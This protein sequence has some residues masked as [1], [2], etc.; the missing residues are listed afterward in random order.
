LQR[1]LFANSVGHLK[2]PAEKGSLA[3]A[4]RNYES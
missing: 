2:S 4:R 3:V 1:I